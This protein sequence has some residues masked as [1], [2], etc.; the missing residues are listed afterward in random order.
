MFSLPGHKEERVALSLSLLGKKRRRGRE[1]LIDCIFFLKATERA[2]ASRER[3]KPLLE[4]RT[5]RSLFSLISLS[6]E[7]EEEEEKE[8]E[9]DTKS[10]PPLVGKR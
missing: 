9:R 8:R 2:R 1:L 5:D 10:L 7:E 3:E 6:E 4:T